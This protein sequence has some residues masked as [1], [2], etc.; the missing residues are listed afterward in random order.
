[1]FW[2]RV[3]CS[4][5]ARETKVQSPVE[6]YQRLKKCYLI[7]PC[8]TFSIRYASRVKWSSPVKGV[9]LF[10]VSFDFGHQLIFLYC[11]NDGEFCI[12][13]KAMTEQKC[14]SANIGLLWSIDFILCLLLFNLKYNDN[15][16]LPTYFLVACAVQKINDIFASKIWLM[17][18][19]KR[20]FFSRETNECVECFD[21]FVLKIFF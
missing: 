17:I 5:V 6:S 16:E 11:F 3:E 13:V 15:S 1:M 19:F 20:L 18:N 14:C 7:R 21:V 9:A 4:P 12:F 10:R 8:L 2:N